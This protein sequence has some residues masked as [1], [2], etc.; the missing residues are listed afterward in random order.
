MEFNATFIVSAISFIVFTMIMNAIFYKPLNK[1][2]AERQ[3]FIDETLEEAES[4]NK[5]SEF[6]LKD[7]NRKIEKT[8]H[9]AKK[10]ILD[11]T[12][13][14]KAEKT[15]LTAEAQQK[16]LGTINQ[17][18]DE[19]YKSESDA[20]DVLSEDIKKLALDISSK[21]LGEANK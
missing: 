6:I 3:K 18:K 5:K 7:K 14:V 9:E 1:I 19:L 10:I 20:K 13:E 4:H 11:R 8:K 16:A 2:V 21:I 15:N 12:D 17:A